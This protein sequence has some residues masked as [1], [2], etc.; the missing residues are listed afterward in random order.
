MDYE[1]Y[2]KEQVSK[3]DWKIIQ[4]LK[5]EGRINLDTRVLSLLWLDFVNF[6]KRRKTEIPFLLK[7]LKEYRCPKVFDSCLGS[8][9]TTIGLKKAG[10]TNVVS[11][12]ID[13]I[14]LRI[15]EQEAKKHG[16]RLCVTRYDWRELNERL[17]EKFDAVLNLGN[18]LTYLFK[19]NDQ[20]KTLS[21]FW[22]LLKSDGKLIIDERN[23]AEHFLKN[24]GSNYRW[25]GEVVYCGKDK[26]DAHPIYI[27]RSM[28]IMEYKHK[29]SGA[30]VHLVLYPFKAGELKELLIDAGFSEI[31]V[32]GNLAPEYKEEGRFDPRDPEFLTYVCKKSD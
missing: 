14:F 13:D 3:R 9:P 1:E 11:N 28:V 10:I 30:R 22:K 26:V 32:Y 27:S 25:S 23:Y 18:S 4:E 12:E 21:N 15:A 19:R 29:K 5:D 20:I 8:G 24:N 31:K 6:E 17:F 7:Q 2:V 16:V